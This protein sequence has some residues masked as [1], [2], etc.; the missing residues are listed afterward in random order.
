MSTHYASPRVP[1]KQG[2]GVVGI[3][4][5]VL[6]LLAVPIVGYLAWYVITHP[7]GTGPA[8]GGSPLASTGNNK[9]GKTSPPNK[10]KSPSRS[11]NSG[12]RLSPSPS[13]SDSKPHTPPPQM[14]T[15]AQNTVGSSVQLIGEAVKES[16][17][18]RNTLVV[19]LF[20]QSKSN[21]NYRNEVA[22]QLPSFYRD[23]VKKDAKGGDS[24]L[25]TAV[26]VYSDKVEFL[27]E[28]PTDD[29][30]AVTKMV[31]E[32]KD[33][34]SAVENTFTAIHMAAEK[35]APY[36]VQK[37]RLITFVVVSDEVGDDE[38]Q[39]DEALKICKRYA[40]PVYVVGI[41]AIPGR[42]SERSI[43]GAAPAGAR[44]AGH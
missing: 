31:G 23:L 44:F 40:I 3:V 19:W 34:K 16:I 41:A 17:K 12:E 28:T 32:I 36:K 14:N 9:P 2:T 15:P 27:T 37:G 30:E 18:A 29:V 24:P 42:S 6:M 35:F 4:S 7:Q 33:A 13:F 1:R 11:S 8:K 26:G 43:R 25:L 5:V 21:S 10:F 20:D 39:L 22:Q 38:A